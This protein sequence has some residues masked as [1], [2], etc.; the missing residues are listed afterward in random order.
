MKTRLLLLFCIQLLIISCIHAQKTVAANQTRK[1]VVTYKLNQGRLGDNLLNYLNTLWIAYKANVELLYVPFKYSALF[2]FHNHH[3]P[4]QRN[5]ENLYQPIEWTRG[6]DWQTLQEEG[7]LYIIPYFSALP[8]YVNLDL[9]LPD[10]K[11]DWNDN[12]F[13]KKAQKALTTIK[14]I[15][16]LNLSPQHINIAVHIRRGGNF[17]PP[18][19]LKSWPIRFTSLSFYSE[20]INRIAF[21]FPGKTLFINLFTDH[22]H[23]QLLIKQLARMIDAPNVIYRYRKTGNNEHSFVIQDLVTM[24]TFDF[25]I[26]P[27]SGFS[28]IAQ[29]MG[30]FRL[31]FTPES[32]FNPEKGNPIIDQVRIISS[33]EFARQNPDILSLLRQQSK[34]TKPETLAHRKLSSIIIRETFY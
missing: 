11:I 20:Q 9:S 26:R 34:Q 32:S 4:Y 25:L 28:L 15:P 18:S 30:D 7:Y 19:N 2:S 8:Q 22:H 23:P 33:P 6:M 3:R 10:F 24:S 29:I 13:K 27:L 5:S 17:D 14:T 31:V 1:S 12:N 16:S 21:L